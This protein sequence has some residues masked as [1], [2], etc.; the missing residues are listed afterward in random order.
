MR[1]KVINDF[2]WLVFCA[3]PHGS[4]VVRASLRQAHC[5]ALEI[6]HRVKDGYFVSREKGCIIWLV[7]RLRKYAI[8][9]RVLRR[10]KKV[11]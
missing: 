1:V 4:V 8:R 11:I 6:K 10:T 5:L 2:Y 7:R 9:N 3:L